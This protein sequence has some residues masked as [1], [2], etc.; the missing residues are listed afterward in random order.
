MIRHYRPKQFRRPET[1][2]VANGR[3]QAAQVRVIS[4]EGTLIGIMPTGEAL[5]LAY[6]Q[7]KDL[8]VVSANQTPPIAKIIEI[9]KYKY[10]VQQK[11][12]QSRKNAKAQELKEVRFTPFMS[13]GDY[14]SRL[15]KV[16]EFLEDGDKVRLS[17]AFKGRQITKQEFGQQRITRVITDTADIATVEIAPKMIG[18]KIMAQLMP[19]KTK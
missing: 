15:K 8:V 16:I 17:L 6:G 4:D 5:R 10:Q 7:D 12:A 19:R 13:D 18:K 3:I 9:N 14:G 1:R 11:E 2:I